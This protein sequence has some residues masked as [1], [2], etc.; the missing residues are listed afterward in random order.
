M[1]A[2]MGWQS[3]PGAL[4]AI[5]PAFVVAVGEK[6][7]ESV[8]GLPGEAVKLLF[9]SVKAG[10]PA[11]ASDTIERVTSAA[12]LP[13]FVTLKFCDSAW[14][15][16][17]EPKL[18][19]FGVADVSKART[20][21]LGS[22]VSVMVCG[23]LSASVTIVSVA[24]MGVVGERAGTEGAWTVTPKDPGTP[25]DAAGITPPWPMTVKPVEP[26]IVALVI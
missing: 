26:V 10:V 21:P 1:A 4:R 5:D 25:F 22:S 13:V 2:G 15:S 3:G 12:A 24:V 18:P 23:V 11:S 20:A 19:K 14:S 9:E 17:I 7:T 6:T 16:T 8:C